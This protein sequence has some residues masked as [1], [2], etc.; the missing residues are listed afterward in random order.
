MDRQQL[1]NLL[2]TKVYGD[3]KAVYFDLDDFI[4]YHYGVMYEPAHTFIDS[5]FNG[6]G[7]PEFLVRNPLGFKRIKN[8]DEAY[9]Y[10]QGSI[11]DYLQSQQQKAPSGQ[12]FRFVKLRHTEK[13]PEMLLKLSDH[14]ATLEA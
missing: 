11:I 13:Y 8:Y 6:D 4:D 5:Y 1:A 7:E 10:F 2:R 12:I 14:Y 3:L 9:D